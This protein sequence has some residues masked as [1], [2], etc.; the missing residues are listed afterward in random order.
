MIGAS[1]TQQ[2]NNASYHCSKQDVI[3]ERLCVV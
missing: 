2:A 3:R 1:I